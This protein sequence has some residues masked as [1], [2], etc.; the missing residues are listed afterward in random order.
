MRQK[1]ITLTLAPVAGAATICALQTIAAAGNLVLNGSSAVTVTNNIAGTTTTTV[2][3]DTNGNAREIQITAVGNETAKTFTVY[4]RLSKYGPIVSESIAGPNATTAVL[5]N[6][7]T[8]ITR[9]AVS[10]ALA[11]NVS[12]GVTSVGASQPYPVDRNLEYFAMG[13]V[14]TVSS[15]GSPNYTVQNTISDIQNQA[16]T[17]NPT[18]LNDPTI[19]AKSATTQASLI[20]PV[21][22]IRLKQNSGTGTGTLELLP[23]GL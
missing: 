13:M 8:E 6:Y 3:C 23:T 1:T 19:A 15:T 17:I 16:P 20:V 4:G 18:W 7:F 21:T 22:A 10:A 12:L 11:G 9:V 14:L 5:I 2:P